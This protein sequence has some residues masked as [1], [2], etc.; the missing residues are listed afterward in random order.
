LHDHQSGNNCKNGFCGGYKNK[1][2]F[3][4]NTTI[5]KAGTIIYKRAEI[6]NTY[7]QIL[8]HAIGLAKA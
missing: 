3:I 8:I 7:V 6:R 5:A 1:S 4:V 2:S